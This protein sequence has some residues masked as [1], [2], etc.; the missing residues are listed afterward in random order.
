MGA[1]SLSAWF[2]PGQFHVRGHATSPGRAER[3]RGALGVPLTGH[4]P[5]GAEVPCGPGS[6]SLLPSWLSWPLPVS[7]L[8][9]MGWGQVGAAVYPEDI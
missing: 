8:W 9:G 2:D 7:Y 1:G 3:W 6:S 4:F 5:A